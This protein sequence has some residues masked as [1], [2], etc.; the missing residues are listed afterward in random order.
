MGTLKVQN[1]PHIHVWTM[2]GFISMSASETLRTFD[3]QSQD[4][5]RAPALGNQWNHQGSLLITEVQEVGPDPSV[6]G[7]K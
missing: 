1:C 4:S 5:S 6:K 3:T 2:E 7:S